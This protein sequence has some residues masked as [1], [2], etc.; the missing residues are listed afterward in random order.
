MIRLTLPFA[1]FP[2]AVCSVAFSLVSPG[3]AVAAPPPAI[4]IPVAPTVPAAPM[5]SRQISFA[6]EVTG[7][8]LLFAARDYYQMAAQNG[9]TFS[10][11]AA[12]VTT[13]G[14][15]T[16]S[17]VAAST[18]ENVLAYSP[19]RRLFIS[20]ETNAPGT[21]RRM[22]RKAIS[23]GDT[24]L[25][26][27]FEQTGTTAPPVREFMRVPLDE[28]ATL[29]GVLGAA[30]FAPFSVG[31]ML[32]ANPQT[33][34]SPQ[35]RMVWLAGSQNL[36]GGAASDVVCENDAPSGKGQNATQ[37]VH[38]YLLQKQ[39]HRIL[40]FEEWNIRQTTPRPARKNKPADD[41]VRITYR[42]EN[43]SYTSGESARSK[44]AY[45]Q[46]LPPGYEEKPTPTIPP[47]VSPALQSADPKAVALLEKWQKGWD[48]FLTYSAQVDVFFQADTRTADSRPLPDFWQKSGVRYRSVVLRRPDSRARIE[49]EPLSAD[50]AWA[51]P[52]SLLVVSDGGQVRGITEDGGGFGGGGRRR[53]NGGAAVGA[54]AITPPQTRTVPLDD[55]RQLWQRINQVGYTERLGVLGGLPYVFLVPLTAQNI[56][57][58][59]YDGP[60]VLDGGE[61]VEVVT[62]T[63]ST[64]DTNGQSGQQTETVTTWRVGLG[65]TDGLPRLVEARRVTNTTGKFERD[66]PP[67]LT[68]TTRLRHVLVD[69][70]PSQSAFVLPAEPK[71]G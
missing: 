23:D 48:R 8:Q 17:A 26:T 36:P 33:P 41:G 32:T 45:A 19:A 1:A 16:P 68:V 49:Q 29:P 69:K 55:P 21:K 54:A 61:A 37:R 4:S 66:Q 62:L 20:T 30:G 14:P 34:V 39:T 40:R 70:E 71:G 15:D 51:G 28:T 9:M 3:G 50:N 63:K 43:Y 24:L 2:L 56:D 52:R 22:V 31:T 46:S 35:S 42:R 10:V 53:R 44:A 27:H 64:L 25:T 58:I 67:I 7:R 6:D 13:N 60:S 57:K 65:T 38:R 59:T 47:S 18:T 11:Q 5:A 12:L